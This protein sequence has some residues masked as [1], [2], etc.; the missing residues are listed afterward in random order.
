[1]RYVLIEFRKRECRHDIE[2][3]SVSIYRNGYEA[4]GF[5]NDEGGGPQPLTW[6]SAVKLAMHITR[7]WKS[8]VVTKECCKIFWIGIGYGEEVAIFG[9]YLAVERTNIKIEIVGIDLTETVIEQAL[10]VIPRGNEKLSCVAQ[11]GDAM[12]FK[13]S[14][15]ESSNFDMLYTSAEIGEIFCI[16]YF[17][18]AIASPT[19]K[20]IICPQSFMCYIKNKNLNLKKL[21]SAKLLFNGYLNGSEEKRPI[22][23]IDLTNKSGDNFNI[24]KQ[25]TVERILDYY[26]SKEESTF[27][28]FISNRTEFKH[29]QDAIVQLIQSYYNNT[30]VTVALPRPQYLIDIGCNSVCE[31][32]T[33]RMV[34]AVGQ[35]YPQ[36][37]QS[38]K[39]IRDYWR[40]VMEYF[41]TFYRSFLIQ[42]L[43]ENLGIVMS[44]DDEEIAMNEELSEPS[45][46]N[47]MMDYSDNAN[48]DCVGDDMDCEGN[49]HCAEG[50]EYVD[51][52]DDHDDNDHEDVHDDES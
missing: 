22:Y 17:Y 48:E 19:I 52:H 21:V 28:K 29:F 10:H 3:L 6:S 5:Q 50:E 27:A 44:D 51:D 7:L 38:D 2:K 39:I 4:H 31:M 35:P 1:M 11:Q 23:I 45:A 16:T 13:L 36:G 49:D 25:R 47:E 9:H 33:A 15:F 12:K 18:V 37:C 8:H 24:V 46:D 34:N 40:R 30:N 26:R 42:V 43:S 41:R 14:Y 20:Y 32:T